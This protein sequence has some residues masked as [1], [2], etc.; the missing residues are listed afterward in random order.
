M[1]CKPCPTNKLPG[2]PPANHAPGLRRFAFL[3]AAV[4]CVATAE[5]LLKRGAT[6]TAN[7]PGLVPGFGTGALLSKWTWLGIL[8]YVSSFVC[9]VQVLRRMPLYLA[10]SLMSVVHV[11]VPLGSWWFLGET[12]S[13]TRWGGIAA[14]LAGVV[15]L[16][17]PA[18]KAEEEW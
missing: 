14:V 1:N 10:F 7:V 2:E 17:A 18:M 8:F 3:G 4:V 9:W 5:L 11:L 15:I 6:A 13:L 12:I 16:A